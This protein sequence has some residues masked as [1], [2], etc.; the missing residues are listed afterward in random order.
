MGHTLI[1]KRIA[2]AFCAVV[3][4][5][6]L[7]QA[8]GSSA[9]TEQRT[10]LVLGDSLTWGTAYKGFGNV[11]PQLKALGTF[12]K[13]IV[14]GVHARNISGPA[15]TS[16][17]GVKT[18]KQYIR[19]GMVPDAVIV[20]LGSNDLQQSPKASFYLREIREL[21]TL[22]GPRPV[23]WVNVYRTDSPSY[24]KRSATFNEALLDAT[25]DFP[26]LT[27]LDW[28]TELIANPRWLAFDKLH[29]QP[30]GYRARAAM[31]VQAASELW[32]ILVPPPTTIPE[33][34]LVETT[35]TVA[36]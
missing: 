13:V 10:L 5:V 19:K 9:A 1:R 16:R 22:I 21:L 4:V 3:V 28:S 34:S 8:S 36:G 31:Y 14:D 2:A 12:E 29:L 32:N 35:T 23:V 20:A 33:T 26:N 30:I 6:G 17:N 7:G 11:L 24:P 18:Y 27:I 15:R 25:S